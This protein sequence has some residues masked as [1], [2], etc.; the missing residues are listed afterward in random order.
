MSYSHT[1][2]PEALRS[3]GILGVILAGGQGKRMHSSLP[4]VLQA[5]GGRPMIEHVEE[6]IRA[7]G[8]QSCCV[9]VSPATYEPIAAHFASRRSSLWFCEQPQARGTGDAVASVAPLFPR[10]APPPFARGRLLSGPAEKAPWEYL[11]ICYGDVPLIRPETLKSFSIFGQQR[12]MAVIACHYKNPQGYGRILLDPK[13]GFSRI[14]EDRDATA[15]ERQIT[16]CNTG[17]VFGRADVIFS[18]LSLLSPDNAQK[19]YYLTDVLRIA[20]E[21]GKSVGVYR[22]DDEQEFAGVNDLDQ[23]RQVDAVL[24]KGNL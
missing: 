23:L 10:Y 6:N 13:G 24:K 11:L 21:R 9:L 1:I 4:K 8:I 3:N 7:A 22:A 14:V 16:L 2:D 20:A 19:E 18:C 5:V 15:E 17:F 12:D